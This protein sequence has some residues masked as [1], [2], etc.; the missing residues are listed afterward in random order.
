MRLFGL[1]F[2]FLTL[3]P[4]AVGPVRG[5]D[6][7]ETGGG[8]LFPVIFEATRQ[9]VL[10][11]ERAG[12]LDQLKYD[13]GD[14]VKKGAVIAQVDTGDLALQKKRSELSLR[15]LN[16]KVENLSRLNKRG[17]ATNEDVAEARMERDVVRTDIEIIKRQI[18][19]SYIRAPF[20]GV[21]IRRQTQ[22]HEWVTAG[23]P[24]VELLDPS[25]LRAVGNI[26]SRLAVGLETGATHSFYVLDLDLSVSGVVEAVVPGVDELSNTAQ[27]IWSVQEPGE[28]LLSGMKGEVRIGG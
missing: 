26:P 25:K 13:V 16:V 9:A 27:V 24:V 28:D 1:V 22:A 21:I 12:S 8:E 20:D 3:I 11:A 23:Q 4:L 15:H 10:S 6:T 5:Q 2:L 7:A 18:S 19:K 17:L 14:A